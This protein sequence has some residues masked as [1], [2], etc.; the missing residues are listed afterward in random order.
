MS[1]QLLVVGDDREFEAELRCY[2]A[3]VG[4]EW[5]ITFAHR[6]LE[7]LAVLAERPVDAVVV[8]AKL[9]DMPATPLL[10]RA[11]ERCPS[12]PRFIRSD[13][14]S[15]AD[16]M[17]CVGLAHQVLAIPTAPKSLKEALDRA[18]SLSVWL[19][20]EEVQQLVAGIRKLPSP[21]QIYLRVV[22]ELQLPN[23]TVEQVGSLIAQDPAIS[24]KLLQLANSAVFGLQF[25]VA[26]A[27]DAVLYLGLETTQALVLLA[28]SF[29]YFDHIEPSVFS[30]AGLWQHSLLAGQFAR[31]IARQ[32]NVGQ[33]TIGESFTAGLL[34]DLGKLVLAANLP[35][36]FSQ[37]LALAREREQPLW[38]AEREVLGANHA[39]IGA[40]LIGIWGLPTA[41]VEAVALH[42]YPA[43]LLSRSFCPLTATHVANVLAHELHDAGAGGRAP[44]VEGDY[45][46]GLELSNRLDQWREA[47]RGRL[48]SDEPK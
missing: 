27:A 30:V 18:L 46:A 17:A 33:E 3:A 43:Q 9:P 14:S 15:A 31:E 38:M 1:R 28:H 4:A 34:H 5:E 36:K 41:I 45:L 7:A 19:P 2:F 12:A 25:Q 20:G 32:E 48:E 42:H 23:T 44:Q 40:C 21:P 6:G 24:A 8:D 16:V 29:S 11:G 13:L 22:K 26:H 35:E 10:R 47:C 39:E 37:A